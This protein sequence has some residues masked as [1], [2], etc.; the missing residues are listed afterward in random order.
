[1]RPPPLHAFYGGDGWGGEGWGGKNS[2]LLL[3]INIIPFSP[4]PSPPTKSVGGEGV[5]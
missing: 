2:R 1:M 4:Q 5:S 3:M